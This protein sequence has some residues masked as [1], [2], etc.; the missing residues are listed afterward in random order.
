[1]PVLAGRLVSNLR[2]RPIPSGRIVAAVADISL[3]ANWSLLSRGLIETQYTWFFSTEEPDFFI[4]HL[5][6]SRCST[7]SRRSNTSN[8]FE[9]IRR[10]R[11]NWFIHLENWQLVYH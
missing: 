10:F 11:R 1:M 5:N 7:K 8:V 3:S 2:T 6:I 9:G 4:Y